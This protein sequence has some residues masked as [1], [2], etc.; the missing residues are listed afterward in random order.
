[1]YIQTFPNDCI[2][3][4]TGDYTLVKYPPSKKSNPEYSNFR[5]V[6]YAKQTPVCFS[7]PKSVP[8][9]VFKDTFDISQCIVEEFVEGTM[10]NVFFHETWK[11][12]TK[13]TLHAECAFHSAQTFAEMFQ[14]CNLSLQELDP[15]IVYSFVMQHPNNQIVTKITAPRLVLVASYKIQN[16]YAV[17]FPVCGFDTPMYYSYASYDDAEHAAQLMNTKGLIFKCNGVRSKLRNSE[18][19]H[20]E[21]LK[22]NSPFSTHYFYLRNTPQLQEYLT[23]FPDD[24]KKV[25]DL[26]KKIMQGASLFLQQYKQCYIYKRPIQKNQYL[27]ELHQIYLSIKPKFIN[28]TETL[29]YINSLPP[30]KLIHLLQIVSLTR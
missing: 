14:D 22:G 5:S 7:P 12:A 20:I 8:F 16:G 26:E 13:S 30:L 9:D 27:Y 25:D 18:H 23:F 1:M 28:K 4:K 21:S 15:T 17:E 19:E 10:I 2:Q 3:K 11:I 29:K 24:K 6:I